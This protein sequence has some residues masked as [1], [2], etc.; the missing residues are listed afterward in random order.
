MSVRIEKHGPAWTVIH[1]RP[2]GRNAMDPES[3][4]DPEHTRL[5]MNDLRVRF[6]DLSE[7]LLMT[8]LQKEW[9]TRYPQY[10][11]SPSVRPIRR[12]CKGK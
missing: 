9:C 3:A 8:E 7:N 2:E 10:A 11:S 5:H 1:S 6:P 12:H 4:Y